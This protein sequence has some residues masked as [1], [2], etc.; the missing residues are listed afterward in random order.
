MK[1]SFSATGVTI[2]RRFHEMRRSMM[3]AFQP[4]MR[5]RPQSR[6]ESLSTD[7]GRL[8][9]SH[10]GTRPFEVEGLHF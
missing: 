7:Q 5:I 8:R 9:R 6:L 3:Q 10:R 2:Q 1:A 4:S